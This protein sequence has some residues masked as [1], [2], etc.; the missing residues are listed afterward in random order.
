MDKGE[1]KGVFEVIVGEE[2][3]LVVIN[4]ESYFAVLEELE[5]GTNSGTITSWRAT[6]VPP[7][8]ED[9]QVGRFNSKQQA[10]RE[11]RLKIDEVAAR[12]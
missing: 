12:D 4:G 11:L 7:E 8:G 1:A 6:I 3:K 5:I 9:I 2:R 10:G